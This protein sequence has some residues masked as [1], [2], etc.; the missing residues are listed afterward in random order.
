MDDLKAWREANDKMSQTT[1]ALRVGTTQPH[2]SAIENGVEGVSLS[3][4]LRIFDR[5]GVRV[6]PLKA[7][8][9]HEI[10]AVRKLSETRATA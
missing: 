2:L 5:T 6:G 1:L 3:L 4:A 9:G 8:N 10:A 7:M